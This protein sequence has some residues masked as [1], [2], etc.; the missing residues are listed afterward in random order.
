[1]YTNYQLKL[2]QCKLK[3]QIH[4]YCKVEVYYVLFV[5]IEMYI[6]KLQ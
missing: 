5:I 1:M 3:L 2:I 6:S 4:K